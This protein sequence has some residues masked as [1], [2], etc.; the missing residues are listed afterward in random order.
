MKSINYLSSAIYNYE[1]ARKIFDKTTWGD[2]VE[3]PGEPV[4]IDGAIAEAQAAK[5]HV[6]IA[7]KLQAGVG[8][9]FRWNKTQTRLIPYHVTML[10]KT[11]ANI[12]KGSNRYGSGAIHAEL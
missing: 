4:C 1:T 11:A 10:P 9:I 2:D 6:E 12:A 8:Y 5:D 7:G 3:L